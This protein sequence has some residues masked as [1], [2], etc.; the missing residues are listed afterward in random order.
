MQEE[1]EM[2]RQQYGYA[3]KGLAWRIPAGGKRDSWA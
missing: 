1:P 2:L 3:D